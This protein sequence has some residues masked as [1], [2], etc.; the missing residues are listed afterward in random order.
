[1][2]VAITPII[3]IFANT[4]FLINGPKL[5]EQYGNLIKFSYTRINAFETVCMTKDI[6][7]PT[8]HDCY[9]FY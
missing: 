4:L 3:Y 7:L 6:C 1:M 8:L 5:F 2:W 9:D